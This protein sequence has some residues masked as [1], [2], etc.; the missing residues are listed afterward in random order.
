MIS[1]KLTSE[2]QEYQKLARDFAAREIAAQA[3][4]MT[5]RLIL[6]ET[7]LTSFGKQV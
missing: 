5:S 6:P 1:H 3:Q 2:Q 7:F 4:S